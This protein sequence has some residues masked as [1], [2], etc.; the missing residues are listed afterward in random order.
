VSRPDVVT[1]QVRIAA[2]P[3]VVFPYFTDPELMTQWIGQWAELEPQA[4]GLFAL[5]VEKTA[6]RGRY[7][8]VDPYTR[9]VFTWGVPGSD[10]I[11]PGSTTV[12][13]VL[14]EAGPDTIVQLLHRDLPPD[15]RA[16]HGAGWNSY[17]GRLVD[18]IAPSGAS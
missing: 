13:V 5:D 14:T 6:V 2:P 3:S 18:V 16:P 8:E 12:E 1:A 11:P 10:I 15:Q 9:I 7:L 17:L 4:G